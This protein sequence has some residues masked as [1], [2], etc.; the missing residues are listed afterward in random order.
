LAI[1]YFY[2]GAA[3]LNPDWLFEAMPLKIWLP[4]NAHLPLIGPLLEQPLT[5]YFFSWAG[6]A[7]DLTIVFFLINRITRPWAYLAVV[8]FH[9]STALLFQIGMFPYIMILATLIFFPAEFHQRWLE[10]AIPAFNQV[11]K[12]RRYEHPTSWI[13]GS[14]LVLHFSIQLLL[15]LRSHLYP[16]DLFWTEEG[17]RFSW[18]VMLMEKAGYAI[19]HVK[20]PVSDREWEVQNW[21]YLTKNQEKMMATQPDMIL[22]FAHY[23][24]QVYQ[25][26][27]YQDLEIRAEC[28]VTLNG[29]RSR[30]LVDPDLDLTQVKDGFDHKDW[31]LPSNPNLSYNQPKP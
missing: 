1:V 25:K 18:R 14:V 11:S 21:R 9:L 3:K 26:Q 16:G 10:K 4:A 8:V 15:P 2:A 13:I 7:Y 12:V 31:V 19:F 24:E 27:G 5:A 17:Y 28:Y 6:A 22:Q 29:K 20:D 30:L 23:L